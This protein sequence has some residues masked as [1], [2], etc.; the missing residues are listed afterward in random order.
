MNWIDTL[1]TEPGWYWW[2]DSTKEL[3]VPIMM[4]V[5]YDQ[6]NDLTCQAVGLEGSHKYYASGICGQWVGP[7]QVPK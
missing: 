6:Y 1:P 5:K 7:L 4:L 2:Q 3:P